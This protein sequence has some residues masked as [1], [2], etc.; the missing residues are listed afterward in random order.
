MTTSE[1]PRTRWRGLLGEPLVHFFAAGGILFG[2]YWLFNK[3]PEAAVGGQRIE[4][5]ANDIRQMAV[6]WLAQ[7][8]APLTRD[9]LQSLVDQK[10]AEEVLFREGMAL[11][12]DRNDEIIKRRVAQKMDFLAADVASMQEPDKA[13]LVEWFSKNSNRFMLPPRALAPRVSGEK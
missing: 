2:A 3:E 6:A 11:G 10:I 4:I 8:R 9:E 5:G 12:L 7:G 1:M 13:E